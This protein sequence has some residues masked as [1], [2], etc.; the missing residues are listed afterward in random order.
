MIR[1]VKATLQQMW[2]HLRKTI[3]SLEAI[4]ELLHGKFRT[5]GNAIGSPDG[6]STIPGDVLPAP[7]LPFGGV[8]NLSAKQSSR[9]GRRGWRRRKVHPM[10]S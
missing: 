9:G 10:S 6:T 3:G 8:I 4:L 7:D 5:S 2:C 1:P